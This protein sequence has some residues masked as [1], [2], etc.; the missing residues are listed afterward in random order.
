M[1]H[2][3]LPAL[4]ITIPWPTLQ[5]ETTIWARL[6]GTASM[7]IFLCS[8]LVSSCKI[9][10]PCLWSHLNK[11]IACLQ[12]VEYI[13]PADGCFSIS[14]IM[15]F[16]PQQG[17]VLQNV[18][19]EIFS[20]SSAMIGWLGPN[21]MVSRAGERQS[22]VT[23]ELQPRIKRCF[24]MPAC[25]IS[26]PQSNYPLLPPTLLPH[27]SLTPISLSLTHTHAHSHPT[28]L[29]LS[30]IIQLLNKILAEGINNIKDSFLYQM[31]WPEGRGLLLAE[32]FKYIHHL[33]ARGGFVIFNTHQMRSRGESGREIPISVCKY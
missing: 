13:F 7:Q 5:Y 30:L 4:R 25:L 11:N 20:K 6:G 12:P 21:Q 24:V 32:R 10:P 26:G 27:P 31:L 22:F 23:L 8:A 29:D 9:K 15:Y 17:I 2:L 28:S 1:G 33:R 3:A 18:K 16:F 19:E 14:F